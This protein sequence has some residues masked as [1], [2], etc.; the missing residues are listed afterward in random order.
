MMIGSGLKK[1]AKEN[2][3]KV[4]NG[5]AYGSLRGYA[6]TLSE[7]SGYKQIVL[8]TKFSDPVLLNRLQEQINR[9]N[10]TREFR[11]QKLTFAPN[12]ISIVFTDNP[13][14]MKKIGAFLD[15]FMPML[16]SAGASDVNTCTE[17]GCQLT[18]GCWKLIDGVAFHL[19]ESCAEKVRREIDE[20]EDARMQADT[21]SYAKGALGAALG[22]L[23]GAVVWAIVLNIGYVASIVGL[24][25][26]WL[27]EKGYHLLHGRQGKGKIAILIAVIILGVLFGTFAADAI[28]VAGMI[29]AGELPGLEYGDIPAFIVLML[30]ESPEY[31][32]GVLGNILMG[33]LFAALGVFTLLRKAGKEVA[34]TKVIDLE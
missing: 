21:G 19:H 6:A 33:L 10:I 34:G 16:P 27:A 7:G 20:D 2:G 18:G 32:S 1:L 9:R 15:W 28:T 8:T 31:A 26:G 17:C 24:L 12:G 25:I 22:A 30:T 29:G 4:S 3:M 11:V 14:T 5:V 23:L 13:G